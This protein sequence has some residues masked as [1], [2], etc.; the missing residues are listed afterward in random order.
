M[1]IFKQKS[2]LHQHHV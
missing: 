2:M 1:L